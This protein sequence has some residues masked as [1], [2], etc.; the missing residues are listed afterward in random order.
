MTSL[1]RWG[2]MHLP[3]RIE[4]AT[5]ALARISHSVEAHRGANQRKFLLREGLCDDSRNAPMPTECSAERFDFG[6]VEG[7]AVEAALM[8]DW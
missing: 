7:R 3:Y 2:L 5:G 4:N 6:R 1:P 8:L